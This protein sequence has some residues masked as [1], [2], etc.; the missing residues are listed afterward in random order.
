EG[1]AEVVSSI[2]FGERNSLIGGDL[3]GRSRLLKSARW[4]TPPELFGLDPKAALENSARESLFY[5]ESWALAEMLLVSPAYAPRFP[6]LLA[7]MAKGSDSQSAIE[8]V[9]R[10]TIGTVFR[11]LRERQARGPLPMPLPPVEEI[12]AAAV[13]VDE[14]SA[15]ASRSMLADL[16]YAAGDRARAEAQYRT[17]AEERPQDPG[18]AAALG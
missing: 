2:R 5:S 18:I 9:Y 1:I 14:A 3:P 12:G 7:M 6:A 10:T 15:F 13:R 16:R 4:I 8:G 11:D 17:L